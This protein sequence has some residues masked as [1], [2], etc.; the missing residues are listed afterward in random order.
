ML[1]GVGGTGF[2]ASVGGELVPLLSG[3]KIDRPRV[4]GR[5]L[6]CFGGTTK[7]GVGGAEKA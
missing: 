7:E 5:F 2:V 6:G 1:S 3:V 4:L